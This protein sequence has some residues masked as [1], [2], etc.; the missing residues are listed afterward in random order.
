[1]LQTRWTTP[2]SA[3]SWPAPVIRP[4]AVSTI[5]CFHGVGFWPLA[6]SEEAREAEAPWLEG[7]W[8]GLFSGWVEQGHRCPT[9]VW[10]VGA[11]VTT[12]SQFSRLPE[13]AS[14]RAEWQRDI[15]SEP[16][17]QRQGRVQ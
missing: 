10:Q 5:K 3:S 6:G 12:R 16:G 11:E 4:A 7:D 13:H 1:M 17:W 9:T 15:G 8:V 14:R 2:V